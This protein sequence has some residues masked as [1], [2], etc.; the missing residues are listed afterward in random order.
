M[1]P[2]ATSSDPSGR[3][4]RENDRMLSQIDSSA[5][6]SRR[7]LPRSVIRDGFAADWGISV[8][9]QQA[10]NVLLRS[11]VAPGLRKHG[12]RGTGQSYLLPDERM[13]VQ[14]GFQKSR[15]STAAA[16]RFTVNLGVA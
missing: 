11:V 9:A 6:R 14:V 2:G 10:F 13:W 12:F 7:T 1:P 5:L 3:T 15:S 4:P 8:S 16:L